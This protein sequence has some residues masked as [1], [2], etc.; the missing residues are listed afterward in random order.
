[1]WPTSSRS[2]WR[3]AS[4]TVHAAIESLQIRHP[5]AR[6]GA[7]PGM[8]RHGELFVRADPGAGRAAAANCGARLARGGPVG[9]NDGRCA[10]VRRT[11]DCRDPGTGGAF[12]E[13]R[14]F[15]GCR[16][17][18]VGPGQSRSIARNHRRG[19]CASAS[20]PGTLWRR[21]EPGARGGDE[22]LPCLPGALAA[23]S[24]AFRPKGCSCSRRTARPAAHIVVVP[25][26]GQTPE[27]DPRSRARLAARTPVRPAPR[28][29]RLRTADS[30][31]WSAGNRSRRATRNFAPASRRGASGCTAR[32]FTWAATPSA[33]K[34]RKC[35]RPW[36]AFARA[37]GDAAKV[38]VVGYAEGGLM[39]FYAAAIDPRIDGA[40]VS[41]YFDRRGRVWTEPI[42]RNVWSLLERFSDA[43]IA[44]LVL[45]RQLV[46]RARGG[47]IVH[48]QQG[49]AA[50]AGR[51]I[52]RGEFGRI[53]AVAR[54]SRRP[55]LVIGPGDRP[56]GPLS[57]EALAAFAKRLGFS[58]DAETARAAGVDRRA[59]LRSGRTPR[60]H[61]ARDRAA[62]PG[63][64]ARGGAGSRPEVS[65][66]GA[67]RAGALRWST[68]KTRPTL[69]AGAVHRRRAPLPRAIP[70]GRRRRVRRALSCRST[71]E[72]ARSPKRRDGR[73]GTWCSTCG[74]TCSPGACWWCRRIL[75]PGER[76]PVVV[77]QHGRN[78]LPRDVDR[79]PSVGL[80][81]LRRRA[82]RPRFHRVR[83]AQPLSRRGPLPVARSQGEHHTRHAL[84]VH[85]RRSTSASSTGLARCP[86]WTPSA[87]RSTA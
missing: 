68:E 2:S 83:A 12:L 40:L 42:D 81:R 25:D 84:L 5:D 86:S 35:S 13:V 72:H 79:S 29:Q 63:A 77:V 6:C 69:P 30:R 14:P 11:P 38:G 54:R 39:A 57:T 26:A 45:P 43:E 47:S 87:S 70:A 8:E 28:Q 64:R 37:R 58:P 1:M 20:P 16:L 62:R 36:T 60:P 33:T 53:P 21:R 17:E 23:C 31:T 55:S 50:D 82:G 76:R 48:E 22:P 41:G 18:C 3:L 10:S 67:A 24:T 80:Q 71:R 59:P 75:R 15:V 4:V 65:A 44:S 52:G 46:D 19:R 85:P 74:R 34:S 49:H 56:V 73:R 66:D 9:P 7:L 27:A 32:R 61:R 78:G 51:G